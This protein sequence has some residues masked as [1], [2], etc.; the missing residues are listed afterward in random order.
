M[1]SE[2]LAGNGQ[3]SGFILCR[4]ICVS[5]EKGVRTMASL[6]GRCAK[7]CGEGRCGLLI[8]TFFASRT[9]FKALYKE[10]GFL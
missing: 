5:K 4:D 9:R 8:S 7:P 6:M 1:R 3:L 2:Q 10:I